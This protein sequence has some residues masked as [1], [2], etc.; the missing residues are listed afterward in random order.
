MKRFLAFGALL[1]TVFL[2]R[3][4]RLHFDNITTDEGLSNKMVLSITQDPAGFIWLATAE[5]LNRYDGVSFRVFTHIPGDE[6]SL[7]ASWVNDVLVLRDGSLVAATEMGLNV[8]DPAD[9]S[10]RVFPAVNDTRNL[11]S[12]LRF[13]CIFEDD[14]TVWAGTSEGLVGIDKLSR[15]L[16]YIKLATASADD[17]ANEVKD[18]L[19]DGRGRLWVATFDGLYLFNDRDFTHRRFEV[20]DR[21][22]YDQENNYI[23]SLCV[24]PGDDGR[25]YVGTSN[26]LAILDLEDFSHR[27][28]RAESTGL[29]NNDIKCVSPFREDAILIG[30][31]NGLSVFSV[32]DETFENYSPSLIDR[33]SLASQTVWC[34]FEDR[35]GE[36]W[37]GTGNG[38][39]KIGR[40][41]DNMEY[42]RIVQGEQENLRELMV[43]DIAFVGDEMWVGTAEGIRVYGPQMRLLRRYTIGESGLPHNMIK[44]LVTTRKGTVWAGTNNGVAVYDAR[45]DRFVPLFPGRPDFGVKY[46]YDMKEDADGDIIVNISNGFCIITPDCAADGRLL[47]ARFQTVRIDGMVSSGNT[48]VT[49]METDDQGRIWFGTINDGLFSYDKKSGDLRQ[50]VFRKGDPDSINS[51]RVYTLYM[52]SR[53]ALWI[54]T[55]MGLCR[56]DPRTGSFI[57]FE[58]DHDL[59]QAIRTITSDSGGRMWLCMLNQIV[60]F[61]FEQNNKIVYNVQRDLDCG[62]LEYNSQGEHDGFLYFG[63]Y[64]GIVRLDPAVARIR[65]EKAPM[66]ITGISVPGMESDGLEWPEKITLKRD[67]NNI[68][69]TFALLYYSSRTDIVYLY[70]L[71]GYDSDWRAGEA[72]ANQASYSGLRPGKYR[73]RV[74]GLNPDGLYSDEATIDVAVRKHPLLQGWAL[75]LYFLAAGLLSFLG[76]RQFIQH[77]RLADQLREEKEE[78]NRIESLNRIKMN[79]FTNISHEFKTPLS[80]ILGPVESLL[81]SDLDENQKAQLELMRQNGNRMLRLL[82]QILDLKKIDN[83]NLTLD[84]SSGDIVAFARTVFA[85]F[86]ENARRRKMTYEFVSGEEIYCSFDKE[87]MEN[88]LY[89]LL[90]NAFKFTPDEG[91]ITLAVSRAEQSGRP[92]V[93]ISVKDSGQGMSAEDLAHIYDRF[94]QGAA[95]SYEKISSTGIGLGLT[96]DFVEL[97]GGAIE[98]LSELGSGSSFIVTLPLSQ[99]SGTQPEAVEHLQGKTLV[100]ID[101]N[102]D[103]LS[104]IKLNLS[105]DTT[106]FT[107][108]V[109]EEGLNLIRTYCPDVVI[110]DIMMPD[111]DGFSLCRQIRSDELTSHIPVIFLTAR[112]SEEDIARG[113]ECGADGYITKPFSIKVLRAKIDTLIE[114]REK[115]K[116]LYGK[117]LQ[118][119]GPDIPVETADDKFMSVLVKSIHANLDNSEYSVKDL[120]RD[121]PYSYLQIYR[122]VKALTGITVNEFI[123]NT[124][125]SR[126]AYLLEHSDLRVSEI[127]YS[128]GFGTHSYFTKCFKE[129]YGVTPKEYA[130]RFSKGNA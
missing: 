105:D 24:R 43:S 84:L 9:G 106:V 101:D 130:A 74:K 40:N 1:C 38:I 81:D 89:N 92:V 41:P 7:G 123:R 25:L 90:S 13:K 79:F 104:F 19:R 34:S 119:S 6:R 116:A 82:N 59:S 128:V 118:E 76:I 44:R 121:T 78:R 83:E 87:K 103:M 124:R 18:I 5:G 97:H 93:K 73:F 94:Y 122:K 2:C 29:C 15:H 67:R 55:D 11:L 64:G 30:T 14:D 54:G 111:S 86:Q 69:F 50:F 109:A 61:D 16:S 36:T 10:F 65:M 112:S 22:P 88:I 39:S 98:T 77:K 28:F 17:R 26:G 23:S 127:M 31:A 68:T 115:L 20:R 62:E 52:D 51:N 96:R 114:S 33:T 32:A 8:W 21:K 110:L 108:S 102:P 107:S 3:A 66:R 125:L 113:Y 70:K 4:E 37:L 72:R 56:L 126:A 129:Y 95:R 49:Y 35:M 100:V 53:G 47:D 46:V 91:T 80:L 45:R 42:Y 48:D 117:K 120:C 58:D 60:M 85:S 63:G 27:F 75:L 71:E 99:G 57:R 12:T